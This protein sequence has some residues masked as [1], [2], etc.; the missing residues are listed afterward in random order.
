[1][2]PSRETRPVNIPGG[3]HTGH[4]R[5][6]LPASPQP[7]WQIIGRALRPCGCPQ[8]TAAGARPG[9]GDSR[10]GGRRGVQNSPL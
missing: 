5:R 2:R 1:M 4:C 7:S 6:R 3:L 9:R 10:E 8:P